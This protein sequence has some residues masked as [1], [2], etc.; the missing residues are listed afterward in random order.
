MTG[1]CKWCGLINEHKPGEY[2]HT[3]SGA[4]L[5]SH[6]NALPEGSKYQPVREKCKTL[7]EFGIKET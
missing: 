6:L 1:K 7:E 4:T 3:G 5:Q 2:F